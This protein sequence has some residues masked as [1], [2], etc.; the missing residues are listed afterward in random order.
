[1]VYQT[2]ASLGAR[3]TYKNVWDYVRSQKTENCFNETKASV[4]PGPVTE[5]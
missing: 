2:K 5:Q 3:D 1:M 4:H